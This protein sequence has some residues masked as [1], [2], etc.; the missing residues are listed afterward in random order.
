[1]P[2]RDPGGK[3]NWIRETPHSSSSALTHSV[4]DVQ[5]PR[6]FVKPMSLVMDDHGSQPHP[7]SSGLRQSKGTAAHMS[8]QMKIL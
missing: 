3:V 4:L 6:D 5:S 8:P 1:M 7:R 2:P